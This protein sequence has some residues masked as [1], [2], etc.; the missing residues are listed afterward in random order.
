M[1]IKQDLGIKIK[2]MRKKRGMTQEQLAEVLDISLRTLSG[3]E[4][5]ENFVTADTLDKIV[6]ALDTTNE[7]LFATEHLKTPQEL[8]DEIISD[9]KSVKKEPEK[10][11]NIYKVVKSLMKE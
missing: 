1:G 5:G 11:E 9:V 8:V 4:I 7:D 6:V 3:I 10:L 2:R